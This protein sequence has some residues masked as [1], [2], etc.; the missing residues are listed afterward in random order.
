MLLR[1][2][3]SSRGLRVGPEECHKCGSTDKELRPYGPEGE[4]VCF[5][6]GMGD[7]QETERQFGTQ[8]QE[9]GDVSVLT[10]EGPV[11]LIPTGT[12]P[13]GAIDH[14]K[15]WNPVAEGE[16]YRIRDTNEWV[17][18]TQVMPLEEEPN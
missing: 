13:T 7:L 17:E 3:V 10:E 5:S 11:P 18:G 9:A 6:C 14:F 2:H 15:F 8:L 16:F 12:I 1:L 4:D